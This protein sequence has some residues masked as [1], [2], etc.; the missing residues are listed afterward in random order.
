MVA[1]PT[2]DKT[3]PETSA[4]V[5]GEKNDQGEYIGMATVTVTASDT[6]S[7]VNKIEY[8]VG[9]GGAWTA[10]TAPVMVHAAGAHKIRYRASDKAGNVAAE[11][12]V[13]FTVVTPPVEDKTPPETTAKVEGDKD[14]DGAYIGKAKVTVTAT[15]ADSGVE[16]IEY[17]LDGGPYLAYADPGRRRPGGAPHARLPGERQGG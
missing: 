13:E 14:S 2:D 11:K 5:T 3:P 9:D 15:D 12:S 16:K 1:P 7:G 17:S 8:A 6:G 10:Y 4:T